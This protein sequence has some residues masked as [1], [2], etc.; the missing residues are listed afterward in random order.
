VNEEGLIFSRQVPDGGCLPLPGDEDTDAQA[1]AL[2]G[3]ARLRD[4]ATGLPDVPEWEVVRHFTRLSQRNWG[5]DMGFYPLGSCTMKHNPRLNEAVARLPGFARIHP[6]QHPAQV[7]GILRLMKTLEQAL[8][9]IS[10]MDAVSLQPPAGAQGELTALLCFRAYHHSRGDTHR[11]RIIVPDSSHGTNPASAARCGMTVHTI[12]SNAEGLTDL[13]A[14]DAALDENVAGF[15]L[16]NP[17]TLGLFEPQVEEICA[18]VHKAGGQVYC[19]GAN[20]NAL[21]GVSRPGDMGFDALHFNVHKTFSTPH[22][23]GGPGAGP[24]SVQAHLEP[25][26]PVP[27]IVEGEGGILALDDDHP[28]SIGKVHSF[29]GNVGPLVKA[30]AYI[31][32]HGA[33]GLREVT[34][35]AVLNANYLLSRVREAYELPYRGQPMHEFVLS[36]DKQKA[37]G[38]RAVDVAKRLLD[39]GFHAPTVYFPLIVSEA[40][41]IEPTETETK[42]AL[43]CFAEAMLAIARECEDNPDV[44]TG[45]PHRAYAGRLDEVQAARKLDLR[46]D[47][48]EEG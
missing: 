17:N 1:E 38:C 35:R 9:E 41:M 26:L 40:L 37:A 31:L 15:M 25:F 20:M 11:T 30:Y 10:G 4:E 13:A 43:D 44:V 39:Y 28:Q 24:V 33:D 27:R 19:D 16:T 47:P 45:A 42:G 18:R 46:H 21:L 3:G 7:Q 32:S 12:A 29:M 22:G 2:L 5:V 6:E 8:I 36:A 48:E 23:G 34:E 14:L